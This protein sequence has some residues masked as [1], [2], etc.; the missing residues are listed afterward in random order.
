[1]K[2]MLQMPKQSSRVGDWSRGAFGRLELTTR[3]WEVAACG[4]TMKGFPGQ[5]PAERLGRQE[6]SSSR[7]RPGAQK[8]NGLFCREAELGIGQASP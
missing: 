3:I 1:M 2:D 6:D 5:E 7:G 8:Q 4:W